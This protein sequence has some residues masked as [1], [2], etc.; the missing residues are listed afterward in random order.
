MVVG[1]VGACID[2]RGKRKSIVAPYPG[3]GQD[4]AARIASPAHEMDV[5]GSAHGEASVL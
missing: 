5:V 2:R 3:L 1:I 4:W